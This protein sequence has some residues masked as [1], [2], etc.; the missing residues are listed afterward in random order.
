MQ[1]TSLR[2]LLAQST[3]AEVVVVLGAAAALSI[4]SRTRTPVEFGLYAVTLRTVGLFQAPL[5]VGLGVSLPR[6][7]PVTS[8]ERERSQSITAAV[9]IVATIGLTLALCSV[10][11]GDLLVRTIFGSS[12]G[13]PELWALV[14]LLSGSLIHG[15]AYASSRGR[16]NFRTANI[17]LAVNLGLIP[18]ASALITRGVVPLIACTGTGWLLVSLGSLRGQLVRPRAL[19]QRVRMLISMGWRRVPGE[20]A[21]FGLT[22]VPPL[23]VLHQTGVVEAGRVSLAMSVLT[24]AGTASAPFSAV[25]LPHVS[26]WHGTAEQHRIGTLVRRVV[27]VVALTV[28]LTLIAQLAASFV[29]PFVFGPEARNAVPAVQLVLCAV[30]AYTTYV[31]LRSLIDGSTDRATTMNLACVAFA[32]FVVVAAGLEQVIG[33]DTTAV[34]LAAVFALWVLAILM[35]GV[36]RRL[37][38]DMKVQIST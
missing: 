27:L 25:I 36:V 17:V 3:V 1:G 4:V 14:L 35:L 9:T 26:A 34:L 19:R 7:L 32:V 28:P 31:L 23:L 2:R 16:L 29:V 15:V 22:A 8:D 5:L 24:L 12:A 6:I 33:S 13:K 37:V 30:P 18:L 20:F 21:L 11:M 38:M 10:L